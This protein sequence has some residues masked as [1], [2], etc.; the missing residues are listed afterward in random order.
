MNFLNHI[1][2]VVTIEGMGIQPTLEGWIAIS[3]FLFLLLTI[4]VIT[5]TYKSKKIKELKKEIGKLK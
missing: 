1:T 2:G 5:T 4:L 3:V